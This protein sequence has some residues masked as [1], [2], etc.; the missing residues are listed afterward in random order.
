MNDTKRANNSLHHNSMVS[1]YKKNKRIDLDNEKIHFRI[2]KAKS[3]YSQYLPIYPAS[4]QI[5][6]PGTPRKFDKKASTSN[7]RRKITISSSHSGMSTMFRA[8]R[9]TLILFKFPVKLRDLCFLS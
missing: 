4:F 9:M 5:K 2:T 3:L 6:Y 7:W 8:K 1:T